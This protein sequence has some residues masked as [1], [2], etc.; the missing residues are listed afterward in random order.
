MKTNNS[1]K[2]P[3]DIRRRAEQSLKSE[4]DRPDE[5]C[6]EEA[7][8]HVH[9]LRVHQIE[10]EMQNEELRRVQNELEISRS[11][12]AELY[13]FAPVGYLT[14]NK[15][16]EIVDLNL[17]AAGM[18]GVERGHLLNRHFQ[19]FVF[20]ADKKEFFAHLKALF[21]KQ[22]RQISEVKLSPKSGEQFYA[23]LESIYME[24]GSGAGVCRTNM[25]DVTLRRRA[26][27]VLQIAHDE[28]ERCVDERTAEL[29]TAIVK[30]EQINLELQD[31]AHV[32][33]HDL[34]EPLRKIQTFCD[35][36]IRRSAPALDST[37][38]NY[39]RRVLNSASRM[40]QLLRDLLLFSR[41]GAE[42][43]PFKRIDLG[44]IV[45]EAADVFE[46]V[47]KNG[48]SLIEIGTMP[49]IEADE[50]QILQL[51]QNLVGNSL[52]F[53]GDQTLQINIYTK[54]TANGMCE[55]HMEDNGIGF[56]QH[57]AEHIFKPFQRLN[58]R[59][60]YE[61]TGMG[62]AICKKIVERHGGSIRAESEPGK[63]SKF[64]IR[65]PVKQI[66]LKT[67]SGGGESNN[68]TCLSP[69]GPHLACP[70]QVSIA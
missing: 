43:Q 53:R 35:M 18:L 50:S 65:L 44:G 38:Q 10:L 26:E 68:K 51:F 34:Q 62:L 8:C 30:L 24:S 61:G 17:T 27:Q 25:S 9:E 64:I 52:K 28:L 66:N 1:P 60:V 29:R 7:N 67:G 40:R 56:D 31:F 69:P 6:F 36:A 47:V 23:R 16:G 39:L 57:F 32:A 5:M 12:Y 54:Q 33:T 20:P 70:G 21:E 48:G 59:N 37:C 3:E 14:L 58:G 19:H 22:E 15:H 13:D 11:R 49:V 41:V 45:R 2:G 42:P 4:P 46:L 55:I 63:G